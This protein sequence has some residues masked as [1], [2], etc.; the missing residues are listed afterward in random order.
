MGLVC[1]TLCPSWR[2]FRERF[3]I[4]IHAKAPGSGN[5]MRQTKW[6]KLYAL[7]MSTCCK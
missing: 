1:D 5:R 6:Q 2:C 4:I 7:E 3:K